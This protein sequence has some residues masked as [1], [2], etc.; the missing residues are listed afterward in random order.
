MKHYLLFQGFFFFLSILINA[1]TVENVRAEKDDNKVNIRYYISDSYTDQKFKVTISCS[2]AAGE[3]FILQSVTGDVGEN[4]EGGKREYIATWDVLK[5]IDQLLNAEF[6]VKVE[7]L[8]APVT[9][10]EPIVVEEQNEQENNVDNNNMPEYKKSNSSIFDRPISLSLSPLDIEI[11]E[12]N[13]PK[14][15]I[16]DVNFKKR[17]NKVEKTDNDENYQRTTL[18][19]LYNRGMDY[20]PVG[21]RLGFKGNFGMYAQARFGSG[22]QDNIF[23]SQDM[24][25]YSVG[26]GFSK[27]ISGK[28]NRSF[29]AYL[30]CG[31]GRWGNYDA[32]DNFYKNQ[33]IMNEGVNFEYGVLFF[34]KKLGFSAGK[35]HLIGHKQDSEWNFGIGFNF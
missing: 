10:P 21:L 2:K 32:W 31:Y 28:K 13:I 4:V 18:Y 34:T 29:H 35:S 15:E 24:L 19:L 6:Y 14:I 17:E 1:Q 16:P 3:R 30:G 5:D 26:G 27:L 12:I 7:L 8:P 33:N 23:G 9:I 25:A 22:S 20:T 11:P